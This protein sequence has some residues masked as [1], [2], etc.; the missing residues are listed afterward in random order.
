MIPTEGRDFLPDAGEG[1]RFCSLTLNST[2]A[3]QDLGRSL[4]ECCLLGTP[5]YPC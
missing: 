5:E 3:V 1:R 4:E 2:G